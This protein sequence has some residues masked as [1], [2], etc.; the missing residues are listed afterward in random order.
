MLLSSLKENFI[1]CEGLV[2]NLE[3]GLL[4]TDYTEKLEFEGTTVI[5]T[6]RRA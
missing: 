2:V 1:K 3:F 5:I 4:T 6:L